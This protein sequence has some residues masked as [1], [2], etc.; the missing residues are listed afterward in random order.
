MVADFKKDAVYFDLKYYLES[1]PDFCIDG[2]TMLYYQGVK[3]F[4]LWTGKKI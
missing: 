3:A 2:K 1:T 4:E